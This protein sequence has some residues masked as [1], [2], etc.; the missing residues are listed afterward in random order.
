MSSNIFDCFNCCCWIT[1]SFHKHKLLDLFVMV[2]VLS[3]YWSFWCISVQNLGTGCQL[4][5]FLLVIEKFPTFLL[6]KTDN[7]TLVKCHPVQGCPRDRHHLK[8][9]NIFGLF[10]NLLNNNLI[11]KLVFMYSFSDSTTTRLQHK[12]LTFNVAYYSII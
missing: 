2:K 4:N 7:P 9:I 11:Q 8:K 12:I 6:V 10:L 3:S 5:A 1:F